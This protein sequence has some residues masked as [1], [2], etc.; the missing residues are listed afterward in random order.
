MKAIWIDFTDKLWRNLN[1]VAHAKSNYTT[2]SE[3][4]TWASKLHWFLDNP[5]VITRPDTFLLN[6]KHKDIHSMTP[7]MR[8]KIV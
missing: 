8:R 5:H 2:Q 7:Q 1:E 6:F 4:Q 3:A